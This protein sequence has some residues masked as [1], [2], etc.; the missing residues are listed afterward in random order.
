M[1]NCA[2]GRRDRA[3]SCRLH[4]PS[5]WATRLVRAEDLTCLLCR[6]IPQDAP[7]VPFTRLA[8]SPGGD[9]VSE[10]DLAVLRQWVNAAYLRPEG[11]GA[12]RQRFEKDGSV[13]LHAFL[14]AAVADPLARDA[15]AVD[16]AQGVGGARRVAHAVGEAPLSGW[17]VQGPP[18][19]QRYLAFGSAPGVEAGAGAGACAVG[20]ALGRL[21]D[22]LMTSEA[23]ARLVG[24]M[25]GLT[26]EGAR[27]EARRFRPGLDYTVAHYG[28]LTRDPRLD[29]SLAIVD[30]G[31][32]D[33]RGVWASGDVGGF[34]CYVKVRP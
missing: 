4:G 10:A 11:W 31:D 26:I 17:A 20:A 19:K 13:R 24:K 15:L 14:A 12:I 22:E 34:E 27:A 23:F 32:D 28:I 8:P 7:E 25:T 2:A 9:D 33:K 6:A 1:L 30:D 29:A 16:A 5:S 3:E 21:R 18:H